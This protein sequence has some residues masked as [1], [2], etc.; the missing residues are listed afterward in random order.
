M[1]P[2]GFHI[3]IARDSKSIARSVSGIYHKSVGKSN[4]FVMNVR[5]NGPGAGKVLSG[6]VDV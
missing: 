5:L 6:R 2:P 4:R 1:I 3:L